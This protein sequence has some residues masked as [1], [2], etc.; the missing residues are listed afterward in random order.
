LSAAIRTLVR[1]RDLRIR[2]GGAAAVRAQAWLPHATARAVESVYERVA[3]ATV[4]R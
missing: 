1:D 3:P 4:S 2:L